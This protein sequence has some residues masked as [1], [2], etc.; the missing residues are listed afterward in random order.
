MKKIAI[1]NSGIVIL[2]LSILVSL[3]YADYDNQQLVTVR[4]GVTTEV[5]D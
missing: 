4:E 2:D 3:I 1:Q 5:Y